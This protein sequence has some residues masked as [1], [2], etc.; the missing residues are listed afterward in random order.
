MNV[1]E[2]YDY[3][4]RARRDLWVILEGALLQAWFTLPSPPWPQ[5]LPAEVPD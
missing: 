2:T 3:L 5:T 4:V 1:P